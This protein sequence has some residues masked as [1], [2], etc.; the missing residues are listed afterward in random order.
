VKAL[1]IDGLALTEDGVWWSTCS[2][3]HSRDP[4]G[5]LTLDEVVGF[6]A[7]PIWVRYG[8]GS[9]ASPSGVLT[10]T[11][12]TEHLVTML[13]LP[14]VRTAPGTRGGARLQMPCRLRSKDSS[15]T[16][17]VRSSVVRACISG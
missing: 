13:Y 2:P 17:A 16:A 4:Y 11:T 6:I 8:S 12:L 5:P 7:S 14:L 9:G 15:G 1:A 3:G 10:A